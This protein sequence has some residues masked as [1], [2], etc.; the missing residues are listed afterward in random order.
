MPL[1][2]YEM[3]SS[4]V[5]RNEDGTVFTNDND[6]AS[7]LNEYFCDACTCDDGQLPD[8]LELLP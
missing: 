7:L 5:L 1:W 2:Y 3:F 8:L 6:K 4:G